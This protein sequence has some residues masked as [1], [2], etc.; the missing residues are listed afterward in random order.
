MQK[1]NLSDIDQSKVLKEINYRPK[2]EIIAVFVIGILLLLVN[3]LWIRI[4]GI[5][6]IVVALLSILLVKDRHVLSIAKDALY[7]Y[8]ED[9][10]I[11]KI[12]FDEIDEWACNANNNG[13]GS[14]IVRLTNQQMIKVVT[15]QIEKVRTCLTRNLLDKETYEKQK[16]ARIN[17]NGWYM[18]L[19]KKF[20]KKK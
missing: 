1:V 19:K 20:S 2:V 4:F 10:S 7:L 6:L 15:F 14:L 13:P 3:L 8:M 18:R 16:Q 17:P 12:S 9:G 5:V 11:E